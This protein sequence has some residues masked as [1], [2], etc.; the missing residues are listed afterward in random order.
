[1]PFFRRTP[2]PAA[3]FERDLSAFAA[4]VDRLSGGDAMF[5]RAQ[6]NAL[7]A[8]SRDRAR[9]EARSAIEASGRRDVAADAEHALVRWAAGSSVPLGTVTFIEAPTSAIERDARPQAIE[10]LRDVA[11]ALIARD[12]ISEESYAVLYEPWRAFIDGDEDEPA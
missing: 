10:V 5:L 7:D 3:P 4:E 2:K 8:G 9:A 6:W 11:Y 12:L 1:M